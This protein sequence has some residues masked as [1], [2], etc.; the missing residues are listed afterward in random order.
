METTAASP[1]AAI[2]ATASAPAAAPTSF[3]CEQ[4]REIFPSR[5][6][7]FKHLKSPSTTC[8]G[9]D[10]KIASKPSR[11]D[12]VKAA[13]A[14][15]TPEEKAAVRERNM[16]KQARAEQRKKEA[17]PMPTTEEELAREI[18]LGG[19]TAKVATVKGLRNVLWLAADTTVSSLPQPVV[20]VLVRRG[21]RQ[22]G[23]WVAYA[24]V[25]CR[26]RE[27]AD[28]W[29][30]ALDGKEVDVEGTIVTL[31][32]RPAEYKTT[33]RDGTQREPL[34]PQGGG[35]GGESSSGNRRQEGKSR[36][37]G[38]GE[39]PG[40]NEVFLAWRLAQLEK[41]AEQAGVTVESIAERSAVASSYTYIEIAG[42]KVPEDLCKRLHD[43]LR[44]T[45]WPPQAQRTGVS[46][47]EYLVLQREPIRVETPYNAL[48]A[49]CEAV[50][51]WA[52]PC[53]GYDHLAITKNFVSSPHVDNRDK[54]HQYAMAFGS[55]IGGGELCV[56]S[57]DG[58]TRWM[59]DTRERLAKFD[60]RSVHWVRG[61]SGERYSVVWYVNKH[62]HATEQV[63]DVD[64]D[65]VPHGGCVEEE[66]EVEVSVQ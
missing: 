21:Y 8:G 17:L 37:L 32:A 59:V 36:P 3:T 22:D 14:A 20:R 53:Y 58:Q 41:R 66:E 9:D 33:R 30:V 10:I 31:K 13:I 25:V 47:D 49:A 11:G 55:Y 43:E 44:S 19:L 60:G 45:L 65:W 29:R 26:S 46:T 40:D 42:V 35:A 6:L 4:C 5:N 24:F 12:V 64:E 23:K 52:D 27:E 1:D 34:Q 2:D 61:Y 16:K 15:L 18:W 54:S 28:T 38:P 7:L 51:A 39:Q 56:E 50:M 62:E 48:K 63:F 57:A